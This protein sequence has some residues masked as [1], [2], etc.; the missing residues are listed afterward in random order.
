MVGRIKKKKFDLTIIP[1]R[2][3][4]SALLA[5]LAGIP[6]RIGFDK[7]TGSFLFTQ[8]VTYRDDLHEVDRNLRLL[9]HFR[10]DLSN[11]P[12][13][14]F[15][16][17]E[18]FSYVSQLLQDS[19]IKKDDRIVGIAPGSVWATKRW[20]PERF[21]E[22]SDLLVKKAKAKVVFLGSK[23]DEKLCLQIAGLMEE[24]PVILAG[25]T[26]VLQSAAIVSKCK[27]VLS[28]D[29]APVHIASAMKKPV[30]AIFGST[31]PEL[32]FGP[33]GE[34]NIIIGKKM[35]C[36]PCGIHGKNEC[37][38]RHFRC[39]MEI[40]TREVFEALLTQLSFRE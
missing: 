28:N 10:H 29:S 9:S 37:P 30:L 22:V 20:L 19:G 11:N 25:K 36:R 14:L 38:K 16:S 21:A 18:D 17:S 32:G 8:K 4:R 34:G 31:I 24:K 5:Y 23:Q 6:E 13:E 3:I 39:M 2:Y 40:T 27:V 35:E 7:G 1:H 33:Y 12:P 15:P 26:S